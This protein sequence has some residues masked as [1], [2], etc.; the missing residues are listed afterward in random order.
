VKGLCSS[1]QADERY[2]AVT[3]TCSP[4][5]GDA[6]V[7]AVAE[8]I[9]TALR[10]VLE[11]AASFAGTGGRVDA[12]VEREGPNVLVS[13]HDNGPGIAPE[14]LAHVFDRFFTTRGDRHGTGLGLAMCKAVVEA[15][16]GMVA[17]RSEPGRGAT[18]AIRL[19]AA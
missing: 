1:L 12:T 5:A 18:F 9:E 17:V 3:I 7:T 8:R 4:A 19:P 11:N 16:G 10:N 14:H 6:G 15:H 2:S 13:V